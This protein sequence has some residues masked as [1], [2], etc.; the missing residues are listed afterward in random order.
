MIFNFDILYVSKPTWSSGL[1]LPLLMMIGYMT[2]FL[3]CST[4]FYERGGFMNIKKLNSKFTNLFST[5]VDIISLVQV[6]F[7][8]IILLMSF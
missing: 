4:F 8:R 6:Q 2:L 3:N 7:S 1:D 5:L